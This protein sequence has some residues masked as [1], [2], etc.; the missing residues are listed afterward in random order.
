MI[1]GLD[2]GTSVIKVAIG[3]LD[4]DGKL[5][6]IA[7]ASKKSAG[8]RNGVI[9]NIEDA[10]DAIREAIE[11]AEQDGGILVNS[12]ITAIG[13]SQIEGEQS[14]GVVPVRSTK[15]N[16]EITAE[17]VDKV[18]DNATAI[19]L[20]EDKEKLHVI[21][22]NYIVDGFGGIRDP[23][24]RIGVRLEAEVF[25]V[26]AAKTIIQNIRTCISRAGYAL[27]GVMLKTLAQTQSVCHEDEMELGSIIIDL[28]AG[29]T[30]VLVLLNG[31]PVSTASVPVGG[32]LVTNDIAIVTGIPV[33]AAEDIKLKYGCC[34]VPSVG[35]DID[36]ILP[37]VGGRAPEII[38]KTQLCQIIQARM[39]QIFTM[40]KTAIM[41]NT[42][43]SIKQLS[44]N[45]ILTG[46]GA[47]FEG[48]VELA[49]AVFKTSSVRLGI[50]EN[51]GG[52][53]E[54][55]RRPDFATVIGLVTANKAL[56]ENKEH[57]RKSRNHQNKSGSEKVS[58]F[59][60]IKDALF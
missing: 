30:D 50:P 40:V 31:S 55:Y 59:K 47:Q 10:K 33:S 20:P 48:V 25:I 38:G 8:L 24:H 34:W 18:I 45:I 27:D 19:M 12:V 43:D 21:P 2:I 28:G 4:E 60:K 35:E 56:A 54:K 14:K 46:G 51:L 13:G 17:D 9:V 1:V 41:K 26:T 53:E 16:R 37:G 52:I 22:Q 49:Q 32:N 6:I 39:E 7:T 15:N 44:G 3:E 29:T 5:Q 36:V 23:I 11:A 58:I 42:N 57:R